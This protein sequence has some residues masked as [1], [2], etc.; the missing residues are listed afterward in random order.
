[1]SV[2]PSRGIAG[3]D[4]VIVAEL[5]RLDRIGR[6]LPRDVRRPEPK[7]ANYYMQ[8]PALALDILAIYR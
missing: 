3:R 4:D 7:Q 1:L 6:R 5:L 2:K 8:G